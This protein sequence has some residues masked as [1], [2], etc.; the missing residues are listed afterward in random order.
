MI[1]R[2]QVLCK[3]IERGNFTRAAEELG[4]SQSAVSQNIKALEEELGVVLVERKKD[5]ISLTTDGE[6]FYPYI[7][8]IC[9]AELALQKK[10]QELKGLENSTI[11]IGTFTRDRKSVV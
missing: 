7:Q 10:Q 1:S 4:Y 8:A 2:Y 9:T 11:R 3:A 5:G 6:Q